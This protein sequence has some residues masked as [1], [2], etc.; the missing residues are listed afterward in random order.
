MNKEIIP[1]AL[2][3]VW[4]VDTP[5]KINVNDEEINQGILYQSLVV[6]NQV[7]GALYKMSQ[8]LR[9]HQCAG[10]YYTAGQRYYKGMIVSASVIESVGLKP[11]LRFYECIEDDG[12][13]GLV[14]IPLYN[15][16]LSISEFSGVRCYTVEPS[17][18]NATNW[19]MLDGNEDLLKQYV[20]QQNQIMKEYVEA[21]VLEMRNYVNNKST[22]LTN[23]I[24]NK[25]AEQR[26]WVN[27]ALIAVTDRW[28]TLPN[29]TGGTFN[30]NF[31]G[32]NNNFNN[33]IVNVTASTN[34]GT[35]SWSGARERS[36]CFLIN[37]GA[38]NIKRMFTN[39]Y[40]TVLLPF[41]PTPSNSSNGSKIWLFYKLHPSYGV[42]F[43]RG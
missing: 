33:F 25:I 11:T 29:I 26:T 21:K 39:A 12:G 2:N 42:C 13:Q 31:A 41:N 7:N 40:N 8:A 6:S 27:N 15:N 3:S 28:K 24:N 19:R 34:F 37:S 14:D 5:N 30:F 38:A 17:S 4:A 35:V 36:G 43:T 10:G 23:F 20:Q 1:Q 16:I 9:A 22:E 32:A 18:L